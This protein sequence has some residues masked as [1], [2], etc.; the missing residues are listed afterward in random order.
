MRL[1]LAWLAAA[2]L[3]VRPARADLRVG[4]KVEIFAG[5]IVDMVLHD[6]IVLGATD[7]GLL[8]HDVRTQQFTQIADASC[9][10]NN[11]LR[12][13][14]LT[15]IDVDAQSRL[16]VGSQSAGVTMLRR[17]DGGFAYRHFFSSNP[18]SE[19]GLLDDE[20]VA[21]DV[22]AD[23][24]VYVAT[25]AGVAQIDL[26]GAIGSYNGEASRR[27][28]SGDLSPATRLHDVAVDSTF[29]WLATDVGVVRYTR[30]PD[31]AT[32]VLSDGLTSPRVNVIEMIGADVFIGTQEG[33]YRWDAIGGF[34][35]RV[36]NVSG[37][38]PD[39]P[40]RSL[41]RLYPV[42]DDRLWLMAGADA[43]T[44]LFQRSSA[45]SPC[46]PPSI[47][48][49]Q[50]RTF[51]AMVASGDT[52]WTSQSNSLG[53]GAFVER[54]VLSEGCGS[55]MRFEPSSIPPSEVVFVDMYRG[56]GR[57]ELW[58]A[59]NS[60]G[61]ARRTSDSWCDFNAND[62]T[63]A[64][65]MTDPEG[66]ASAFRVDRGGSVWF[67][68]LPIDQRTTVDRLDAD[69]DCDHRADLWDHIAPDELGFGGRYWKIE[70][71]GEGNRFFLSDE[72]LLGVG[73]GGL[74]VLSADGQ[75]VA[76]LR[77]DL[78]GGSVVGAIAFETLSGAWEKAWLGINSRADQGLLLWR[79]SGQL[80]DPGPT[81]FRTL[82]LGEQSINAYRDLAFDARHQQLWIGTDAGLVQY[83]ELR[84][85]VIR[86]FVKLS[87]DE[88]V[89]L[90]SSK[91]TDLLVDDRDNLWIGT[92]NGLNRISLSQAQ[93]VQVEA[94]STREKIEELNADFGA[95]GPYDEMD[96]A[97][98]P[99][100]E[101]ESLAYDAGRR[102]LHI[103]T[104]GGV[105][106]LDVEAFEA[107]PSIPIERAVVFPNPV[108]PLHPDAARDPTA[109]ILVSN[110]TAPAQITIYNLEGQI[111]ATKEVTE[112]TTDQE[113]VEVW[114][115]KIATGTATQAFEATSGVYFVRIDS[116]TGSTVTPIVVI[117]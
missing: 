62:S 86:T 68:T 87:A 7:G 64:A 26:V 96:R 24:A 13:N 91:V 43:G 72:D 23:E 8:F 94:F 85:R 55:W 110:V 109:R 114:D 101:V 41:A 9:P 108:R 38:T 20:V 42:G 81:N 73:P 54:L 88:P 45:W 95:F 93:V 63:V 57:D 112:T 92:E 66:H 28:S 32:E 69:L 100:P 19:G 76:N 84:E 49:L 39:F 31:Y 10:G 34:W 56:G 115:L 21:L 50:D 60:A 65:N 18:Q 11:C 46:R 17:D 97:P 104:R 2:C 103:G 117:R 5:R 98:L 40:V 113:G 29:V 80:F 111:V 105:A 116:P 67:T 90:L 59:L 12:S 47:P 48:L 51:P 53:E 75:Q 14:R 36:R 99:A 83:D 52:V 30:L 89:G 82:P 71:D 15:A 27:L 70:L 77:S 6:G 37:G 25:S 58:V 4:W 74:E 78:L 3:V 107:G 16:W 35:D 79:R 1:T 22:W 61:V 44:W 33:V 102:L 106:T